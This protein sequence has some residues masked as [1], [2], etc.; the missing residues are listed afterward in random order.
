M[1]G[2]VYP[3]RANAVDSYAAGQ[4]GWL[5]SDGDDILDPLDAE[6]PI[7]IDSLTQEDNSVTVSGSAQIIP[8]P[9][10]HVAS[11][12]INELTG[13]QY[14]ID[15]GPWQSAP[16]TFGG[17]S[18]GYQ[19]TVA[20]LLPGVHTL[21]VAAVDSAG[22]M[23]DEYA[24]E[25]ITVID[26]ADNGLHTEL[27]APDGVETTAQTVDINGLAR[28]LQ[29]GTVTQVMYRV[30][31]GPWQ[32]ATPQ[33]GVFNSNY[34]PFTLSIAVQ[35]GGTHVVEARA[36]DSSGNVEVNYPSQ[37]IQFGGDSQ[38]QYRTFLPVV[39]GG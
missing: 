23:S 16:G 33:D 13:V 12:T 5:D 38:Q 26:P 30:D 25:T 31:G 3:Y 17:T 1:R 2:Q 34:E 8:Y 28:H 4:L 9:A 15:G 35:D 21:D 24:A 11:V 10:S 36:A 22:N 7:T 18:A 20:S 19:F 27:Y 6:L 39:I 29:G 14:R 37:E 32:L